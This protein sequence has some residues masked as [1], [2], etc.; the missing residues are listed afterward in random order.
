MYRQ[1]FC[2]EWYREQSV[3]RTAKRRPDLIE[4]AELTQKERELAERI[5]AGEEEG[6]DKK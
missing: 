1:C 2:P 6:T 3:I 4:R 5:M